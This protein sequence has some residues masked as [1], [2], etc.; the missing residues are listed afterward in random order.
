MFNFGHIVFAFLT[1][2][3]VTA[4]LI[5]WHD[6]RHQKQMAEFIRDGFGVLFRVR[7]RG[8]S[9]LRVETMS[10]LMFDLTWEEA[11]EKFPE[12]AAA[13]ALERDAYQSMRGIPSNV[14]QEGEA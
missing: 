1:G 7:A 5:G 3:L 2:A 9:G 11:I 10:G 13:F 8:V 6:E 4:W 14:S 12:S